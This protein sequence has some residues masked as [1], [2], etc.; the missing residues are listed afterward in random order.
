MSWSETATAKKEVAAS[1]TL[2]HQVIL[3]IV[4]LLAVISIVFIILKE[5]ADVR[6]KAAKEQV[7][8]AEALAQ[9]MKAKE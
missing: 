1:W 2:A 4:C 3:S 8:I 5:R 7:D 9:A 6:L